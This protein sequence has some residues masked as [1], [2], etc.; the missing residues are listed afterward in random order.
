MIINL[1]D[2]SLNIQVECSSRDLGSAVYRIVSTTNLQ[3]FKSWL[4]VTNIDVQMRTFFVIITLI[5][6]LA[7]PK[8]CPFNLTQTDDPIES[9]ILAKGLIDGISSKIE[10]PSASRGPGG[11]AAAGSFFLPPPPPPTAAQVANGGGE[12]GT[13]RAAPIRAPESLSLLRRAKHSRRRSLV[14]C[15]YAL[16]KASSMAST[17]GRLGTS[18]LIPKPPSLSANT[19]SNQLPW[20]MSHSQDGVKAGSG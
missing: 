12:M 11:E 8:L 16:S 1:A 19:N 10:S 9:T 15:Q 17:S 4:D 14:C 7:L 20:S 18:R 6:T 13:R 3:I 2:V 5:G